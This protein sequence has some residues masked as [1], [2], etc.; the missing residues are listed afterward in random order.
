MRALLALLATLLPTLA[1]AQPT[2]R[3]FATLE[4]AVVRLEDLFE[5]TGPLGATPLGPAPPPGQRLVVEA[6][7]LAAIARRSG[8]DWRPASGAD[9]AVLDRPGRAL[10]REEVLEALRPALLAQGMEEEAELELQAFIPPLVPPES[11]PRIL[12]EQARFEATTQRFAAG[13]AIAAEGMATQRLRLSGRAVATRP[14]VL[15]V[16]R[17]AAGEVVRPQDVR[18]ARLPA[19]QIRPGAVERLDQAVG[20]ALRRPAAPGQPLTAQALAQPLAVER[21]SSVIMQYEIPGL[22]VTAQGRALEGAARGAVLP[23]MNLTSRIVVEAR[24]LGP[25][26]VR[27]ESGR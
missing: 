9:R 12:V 15:A 6:P 13:L 11:F 1:A 27:V 5:G 22:S 26:R 24:V 14:V 7:Q 19:G 16:R 25:G 4:D 20:Q 3:P 17:L 18:L 10:G 8:L 23:V 2:L 21:G